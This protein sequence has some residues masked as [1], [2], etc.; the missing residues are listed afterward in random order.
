MSFFGAYIPSD[1][2]VHLRPAERANGTTTIEMLESLREA[3]PN[4][5]LRV[6]WDGA[7][8]HRSAYVAAEAKRLRIP[9]TRLPAYSPDFMPVEALAGT[10]LKQTTRRRF[11]AS[12][13]TIPAAQTRTGACDKPST[14]AGYVEAMRTRPRSPRALR[15]WRQTRELQSSPEP[16][17]G[18]NAP[19][20][21]LELCMSS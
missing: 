20:P 7:S 18:R 1:V 4:D 14:A 11:G 15:S 12:G 8:Y 21:R 9:L 5:R 6:V 2:R 16:E 17:G 10:S 3:Y 19:R 13:L